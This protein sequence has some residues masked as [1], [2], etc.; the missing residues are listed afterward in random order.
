MIF[1]LK[2]YKLFYTDLEEWTKLLE[3]VPLG[4]PTQ[5]RGDSSETPV[6]GTLMDHRSALERKVLL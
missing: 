6:V 2:D 4:G 5:G 3:D 1:A